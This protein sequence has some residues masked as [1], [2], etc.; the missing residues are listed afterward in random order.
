MPQFKTSKATRILT[1]LLAFAVLWWIIV[2]GELD[3]WIIGLPAALFAALASISLS[4]DFLPRL[5]VIGLVRF[6]SSLTGGKS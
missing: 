3:A 5:S 2:Q 6:T 1:R 4:S